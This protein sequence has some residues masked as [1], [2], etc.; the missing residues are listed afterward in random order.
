M[1]PFSSLIV[2]MDTDTVLPNFPAEQL[3]TYEETRSD[4][5]LVCYKGGLAV[6]ES[7]SLSALA[8]ALPE[9]LSGGPFGCLP[10]GLTP[11]KHRRTA[12]DTAFKNFVEGKG[13][14]PD[15]IFEVKKQ[16]DNGPLI[17]TKYYKLEDDSIT[18]LPGPFTQKIHCFKNYK[19]AAQGLFF[20]VDLYRAD[21]SSGS[22]FHHMRLNP[23]TKINHDILRAF[24]G[25][26]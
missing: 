7:F 17:S 19:C 5:L 15:L 26:L 10:S 14:Y 8:D 20:A 23:Y 13:S 16:L 9:P 11:Y 6:P 1:R 18:E 22:N 25:A 4:D 21:Q 12:R 2:D 3:S 24:F